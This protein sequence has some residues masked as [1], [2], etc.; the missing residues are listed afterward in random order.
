MTTEIVL[1]ETLQCLQN[2]Q[3]DKKMEE[4]LL[5]GDP[6]RLVSVLHYEGLTSNALTRLDQLVT[7]EL[8]G[9]GF[10]RVLVVV[11]A[12]EILSQN[13]DDLQELINH[14]LT[15][16]VCLWF[17]AIHDLLTSDFHK[18]STP[19]LSLTEEFYDYFLLLGQASLPV[20]QL[21][22][23]LLQLSR[24]AMETEIYFP[25]RLE[26][27]RIFN[28]I[29]GSLSR[30]GLRLFQNDENQNEILSQL[31]A[32]IPTVGDYEL[33]VSLS[34]ALCRLTPKKKREPKAN[35]WFPSA[36]ISSAFC[37]IKDRNFEGDCRRFLN[38]V[39]HCHG[40]QRRVY[41]FPCLTAFL[42]STQLFRPDDDTLDEF[43]IDFNLGSGCVS[44]FVN[45]PEGFLWDSIHLLREEVTQYSLQVKD[46]GSTSTLM[47][48]SVRLK[49][50]IM[51]RNTR[52]QTVELSFSRKHQGELEEAAAQVFTKAK[53]SPPAKDTGCP[54]QAP[55]SADRHSGR[56][57][58]RK[59]PQSKSRLKILP[60]S[61]VSSED[62][63]SVTETPVKSRA[64][65]LFDQI[66]HS[67]PKSGV[68]ELE[69][70]EGSGSALKQEVLVSDRKRAASD[71]GYLS[72]QIE[73][74]PAQKRRVDP[75]LEGEGS[76][77][78]QTEHSPEGLEPTPEDEGLIGE[79]MA[80]LIQ[81][82]ELANTPEVDS[83]SDQT[84][85]ITAAFKTFKEQLQQHFTTNRQNFLQSYW[86]K[87]EN[88]VLLSLKEGQQHISSLLTA[89]HQHRLLL[90]QRFES[91]IMD[92]LNQ[93]EE[94]STALNSINT[95]ILVT[96]RTASFF[97]SEMQRLDS[98]CEKHLQRLKSLENAVSGNP[99]SQ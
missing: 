31:A 66:L 71:S 79:V 96:T 53:S 59:K 34:E 40:D 42:D 23:V 38:I 75:Q 95:Q 17:K 63:D 54:V 47:V 76:N 77:S 18:S 45:E 85:G 65:F 1:G 90:L 82:A 74:T 9:S 80:P 99:S 57:Y 27:I 62:E 2:T 29:L 12:L 20:C 52:G 94:D 50:P 81:R 97:Q 3:F 73:G 13:K 46:D 87:T 93:L 5:R 91:S 33:Q 56:S 70:S 22:E 10:S 35:Q 14:G 83:E 68:P 43:W 48:F 24:V 92:Q 98:F 78:G 15:A 44:F 69:T 32:M 49:N 28:S 37:D 16:Q 26:A 55:S 19:L 7:K 41:T 30:E 67:T 21:S 39:N 58:S 60:L 51:H 64:E 72:H 6:S 86:H 88:H 89:V 4:C 84:S 8:C 36:D 11:K 25:L 61:S